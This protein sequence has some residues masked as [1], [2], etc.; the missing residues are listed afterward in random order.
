ML[1]KLS[2]LVLFLMYSV[3]VILVYQN[4]QTV[5][6]YIENE[7][8]KLLSGCA[9]YLLIFYFFKLLFSNKNFVTELDRRT[10]WISTGVIFASIYF[11][12][13]L[14]KGIVNGRID[15]LPVIISSD[16]SVYETV[17]D[18]FKDIDLRT[19]EKVLLDPIMYFFGISITLGHILFINRV[20]GVLILLAAFFIGKTFLRTTL[21]CSQYAVFRHG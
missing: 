2:G 3:L 16:L 13:V 5:F 6:Y 8:F 1:Q 9:L 19:F 7:W 14:M 20:V 10:K 18:Y 12:F 17:L 4:G 11:I 21:Q 15:L